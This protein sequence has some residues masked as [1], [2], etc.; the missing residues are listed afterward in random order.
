MLNLQ[1]SAFSTL[2]NSFFWNYFN[3]NDM[4]L[5]IRK[6]SLIHCCVSSLFGILYLSNIISKESQ[7]Y[8]LNYSLGY[9]IHDFYIYTFKKELYDE[10]Y[11]TYLH[12]GLFLMGVLNYNKYPNLYSNL[13]LAEIST[14][15]LNLR[16][17]YK[18]NK[19]LKINF[20]LLFYILFLI[21][22]IGN[23]NYILYNM[24]L[25]DEYSNYIIFSMFIFSSLNGY[26]FFLMTKKLMRFIK[27]K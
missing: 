14:I 12:H 4:I 2:I 11:I 25:T 23:C 3:Q 21:L 13:I 8:I 16:Y 6:N 5:A 1:L 19:N 18:K 27:D 24:L 17:I 22:R 7:G 15:P 9:I 20:S 26:W 10:K